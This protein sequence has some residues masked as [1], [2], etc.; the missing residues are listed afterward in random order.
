[1]IDGDVVAENGEMTVSFAP[2][3]YPESAMHTMHVG[4]TITPETFRVPTE[5]KEEG[6]SS[7]PSRSSPPAWATMSGM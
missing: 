1:M 3:E 4:E 7:A 5:E 2:H 6:R